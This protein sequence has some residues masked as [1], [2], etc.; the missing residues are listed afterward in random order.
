MSEQRAAALA[1]IISVISLMS[2]LMCRKQVENN[3]LRGALNRMW[4]V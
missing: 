2:F 3:L 1:K 4:T